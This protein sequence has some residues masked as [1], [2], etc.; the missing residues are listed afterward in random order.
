MPAAL[1]HSSHKDAPPSLPLRLQ[2]DHPKFHTVA[3][4]CCFNSS[5]WS[6]EG[7][8]GSRF[9]FRLL[10]RFE[11]DMCSTDPWLVRVA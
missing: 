9:R 3:E 4:T 10:D 11:A 6:S 2:I 5:R 7:P 8:P 1:M